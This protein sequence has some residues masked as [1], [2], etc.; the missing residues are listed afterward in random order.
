MG[1]E[2]DSLKQPSLFH[3]AGSRLLTKH[4]SLFI[5]TF[6]V[7]IFFFKFF[8]FGHMYS[9]ADILNHWYYPWAARP[10]LREQMPEQK[11]LHRLFKFAEKENIGLILNRPGNPEISDPVFGANPVIELT[12]KT[13]KKGEW[14]FWNSWNYCGYNLWADVTFT[15]LYPLNF[16]YFLPGIPT[17]GATTLKIILSTFLLGLF[18]FLLLQDMERSKLASLAGALTFMFCTSTVSFLEFMPFLDAFLWLPALL[19]V[20]RRFLRSAYFLNLI[21]A[22]PMGAAVMLSKNPKAITYIFWFLLVYQAGCVLWYR[23]SGIRFKQILFRIIAFDFMVFVV[24]PALSAVAILPTLEA[25]KE[26]SRI[27]D[28]GAFLNLRQLFSASQFARFSQS[29]G[30]L[31]KWDS[32]P[33]LSIFFPRLYGGT[34]VNKLWSPIPYVELSGYL[35]LLPLV[36]I[37]WSCFKKKIGEEAFFLVMAIYL[38]LAFLLVPPFYDLFIFSVP[39]SGMLR[40][41][42]LWS[43]CMAVLFAFSIDKYLF[44]YSPSRKPPGIWNAWLPML[45]ISVCLMICVPI[46]FKFQGFYDFMVQTDYLGARSFLAEINRKG[47]QSVALPFTLKDF[48]RFH[49][50]QFAALG[51]FWALCMLFFLKPSLVRQKLL[52]LSF[53]FIHLAYFT[54]GINPTIRAKYAYIATDTTRFLKSVINEYRIE[55]YGTNN[56]FPAGLGPFYGLADAAGRSTSIAPVRIVKLFLYLDPKSPNTFITGI[57]P[58][59]ELSILSRRMIDGMAIRY[60]LTSQEIPE[61]SIQTILENG[62]KLIWKGEGC[63]VYENLDVLPRSFLS[64]GAQDATKL[65]ISTK[66]FTSPSGAIVIRGQELS[67][68]EKICSPQFDVSKTIWVEGGPELSNEDRLSAIPVKPEFARNN[69]IEY[70]IQTDRQCYLYVAEAFDKGWTAKV[71]GK[72][73]PIYRANYAFRAIYL[74]PGMHKITFRYV[75][76]GFKLGLRVSLWALLAVLIICL[77]GGARHVFRKRFR[78]SKREIEA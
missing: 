33:L 45:M 27:A 43:F 53:V 14:P 47:G 37:G 55:R 34:A 63:F 72:I 25:L 36:F 12:V 20:F 74:N 28:T 2:I 3:R 58:F 66:T 4:K 77:A 65:P 17:I 60:I 59:S 23:P 64:F 75:P 39:N 22:V 18:M 31:L 71:D 76:P 24:G 30:Y 26:T 42:P 73:Q 49:Y 10:D 54:V 67:T 32:I 7:I 29:V 16:L 5:L 40:L 48:N 21:A 41:L 15:P 11:Y 62:F 56:L 13:I 6:F 70:S 38:L 61:I 50:H 9:P 57:V 51:V 78:G 69:E 44:W 8:F 52:F 19:L 68:L 46:I 1:Q 35:G